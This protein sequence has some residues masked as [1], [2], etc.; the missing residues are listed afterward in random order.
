MFFGN[1][2]IYIIEHT[3]RLAI[4]F[5]R[6]YNSSIFHLLWRVITL[7]MNARFYMHKFM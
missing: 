7:F 5:P 2:K 3:S 6:K 1:G 4:K